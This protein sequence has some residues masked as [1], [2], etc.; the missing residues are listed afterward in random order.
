MSGADV[1]KAVGCLCV[2]GHFPQAALEKLLR[3]DVLDDLLNKGQGSRM[4]IMFFFKIVQI[5]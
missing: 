4:Q 5:S 3:N 1:L 2:F